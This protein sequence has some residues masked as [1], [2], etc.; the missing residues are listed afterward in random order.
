[1]TVGQRLTFGQRLKRFREL[2]GLSQNQ[3]AQ[4]AGV[5]HPLISMV[6]SGKHHAVRIETA[7]KLARVLHISLD[8]LI[9][10]ATPSGGQEGDE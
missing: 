4:Q 9:G 8:E 10:V 1:M 7:V 3:L 2:Q 5:T 6:E